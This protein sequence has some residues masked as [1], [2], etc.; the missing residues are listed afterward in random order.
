MQNSQ[1]PLITII[2][3]CYNEKNVFRT[4]K[5]I[6][7]QTF[8]DFEWLVFDGGSNAETLNVFENFRQ[9]IDI[10]RTQRDSGI[11]DAM[12]RA[13]EAS[14]GKW[15]IF[16]NAGDTFF[17]EKSLENVYKKALF[18]ISYSQ[19]ADIIYCDS[20]YHTKE[21]ITFKPVFPEKLTFKFWIKNCISHQSAFIK[22]E[23]FEKSGLYDES[24]KISAD[25]EKWLCFKKSGYKFRHLEEMVSNYY[26]D[27]I[28]AKDP[29][30][31][32][33]RETILKKYFP[34]RYTL[35]TVI[36]AMR[37]AMKKIHS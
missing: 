25:L 8:Q 24:F 33:E 17:D 6:A 35:H 23:L 30:A 16:M 3:V 10:F 11:Y 1:K 21:G 18:N 26:M 29:L 15:L 36:Q 7:E 4:C 28:S 31:E 20:L 5:S 13:I 19:N 32:K 37:A 22:K 34:F 2:T 9:R 27:G 12:N 14:S